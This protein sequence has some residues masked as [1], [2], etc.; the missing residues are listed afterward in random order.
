MCQILYVLFVYVLFFVF[1]T[2]F[3]SVDGIPR[4]CYIFYLVCSLGSLFVFSIAYL[5]FSA[6][7][8]PRSFYIIMF[9]CWCYYLYLVRYFLRAVCRVIILRRIVL[10]NTVPFYYTDDIPLLF[11]LRR[12][13]TAF[14]ARYT[15]GAR[16]ETLD[17]LLLCGWHTSALFVLCGWHTALRAIHIFPIYT[18]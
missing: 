18:F 13:N 5:F 11:L 1:S 6:D 3:V 12:E 16:N 9:L 15:Y 4:S 7:G 17:A 14:Y 8:I 10:L 2:L